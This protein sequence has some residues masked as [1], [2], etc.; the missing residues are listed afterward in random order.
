VTKAS[1]LIHQMHANLLLTLT[2][3]ILLGYLRLFNLEIFYGFNIPA[4][5]K[6]FCEEWV[7]S[8]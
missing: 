7:L 2:G 3:M 6:K 8:D 5:R 1:D 4:T